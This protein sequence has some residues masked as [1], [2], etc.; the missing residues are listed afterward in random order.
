M[1]P[2]ADGHNSVIR[3]EPEIEN[4]DVVG[5]GQGLL[6]EEQQMTAN[7]FEISN[8]SSVR[9]LTDPEDDISRMINEQYSEQSS[10]QNQSVIYKDDKVF[11]QPKRALYG[12]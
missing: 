4:V 2:S 7:D 11:D 9:G 6:R 1:S 10:S 12:I 5:A 8:R 3:A